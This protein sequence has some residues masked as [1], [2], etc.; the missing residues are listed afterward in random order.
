MREKSGGTREKRGGTSEEGRVSRITTTITTTTITTYNLQPRTHNYFFTS[1]L[2]VSFN[3]TVL[4]KTSLSFVVYL[5][6][7]V[8]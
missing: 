7:S 8:K 6:S 3:V 2:Q 4:L 5:L 1:L